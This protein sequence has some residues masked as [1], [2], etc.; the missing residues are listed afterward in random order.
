MSA[1]EPQFLIIPHEF[2]AANIARMLLDT[3]F[4]LNNGLIEIR[5]D[6]GYVGRHNPILL[7]DSERFPSPYP[8]FYLN[9]SEMTVFY[10]NGIRTEMVDVAVLPVKYMKVDFTSESACVSVIKENKDTILTRKTEIFKG[11]KFCT[12]SVNLESVKD[13]ISLEYVRLMLRVSGKIFML[14]QTVGV[15]HES[16]KMCGQVIFEG[17]TPS[18][19]LTRLSIQ[20]V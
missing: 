5:D 7:I 11:S 2:E 15:L 14:N 10:R 18:T 4:A 16:T 20:P 19:K 13:E 9:E 12:F 3:D 8:I 1:V 6:G 17:K